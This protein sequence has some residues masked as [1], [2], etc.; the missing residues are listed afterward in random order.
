MAELIDGLVLVTVSGELDAAPAGGG[1]D[2]V[3]VVVVVV[4]TVAGDD[5]R[6]S[7]SRLSVPL[8]NVR[9]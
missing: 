7:S 4:D 9:A 8:Q 2:A 5:A 3:V 6:C 1:V